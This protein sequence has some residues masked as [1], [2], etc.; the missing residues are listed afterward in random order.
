MPNLTK[1]N[2]S[3]FDILISTIDFFSKWI[4]SQAY[5]RFAE[6]IEDEDNAYLDLPLT[7]ER[8]L[9]NEYKKMLNMWK[10][11]QNGNSSSQFE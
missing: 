3:N 6:D 8:T 10:H 5:E 11:N 7:E 2:S 9:L 4:T 1:R